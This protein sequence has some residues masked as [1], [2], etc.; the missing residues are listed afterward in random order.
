MG[1][2]AD[3]PLRGRSLGSFVVGIRGFFG[4]LAVGCCMSALVLYAKRSFDTPQR[5]VRAPAHS[6]CWVTK[7][8]DPKTGS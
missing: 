2:S 8:C 6:L 7:A 4:D 5:R 3:P 1:G